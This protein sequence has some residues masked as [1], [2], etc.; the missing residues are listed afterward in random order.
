MNQ[1]LEGIISLK[2][3]IDNLLHNETSNS[4]NKIDNKTEYNFYGP[5]TLI[6]KMKPRKIK[7]LQGKK[8]IS[9]S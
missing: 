2:G 8:L 7:K 9:L 1:L 6:Q 4:F 3:K 5:I